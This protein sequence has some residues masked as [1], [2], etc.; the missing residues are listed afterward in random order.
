M[1]KIRH[2]AKQG[3]DGPSKNHNT[4][5]LWEPAW[6][7]SSTMRNKQQK[8]KEKNKSLLLFCLYLVYGIIITCYYLNVIML[9]VEQCHF[10][11][12]L[13]KAVAFHLQINEMLCDEF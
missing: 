8:E 12:S 13:Y 6:D 1:K 9:F 10:L 7:K 11:F 2:I 4:K 5:D 3:S